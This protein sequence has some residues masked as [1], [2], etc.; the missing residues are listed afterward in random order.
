MQLLPEQMLGPLLAAVLRIIGIDLG[1]ADL[2]LVASSFLFL[3]FLFV[4]STLRCLIFPRLPPNDRGHQEVQTPALFHPSTSSPS[5]PVRPSRLIFLAPR[6]PT[7][8]HLRTNPQSMPGGRLP[9]RGANAAFL[10][11]DSAVVVVVA[12]PRCGK[13]K[14]SHHRHC[15]KVDKPLTS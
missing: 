11:L 13:V 14:A 3:T 8:P 9:P 6:T 1:C 15:P 2:F 7:L 4:K 12:T 5:L 10:G